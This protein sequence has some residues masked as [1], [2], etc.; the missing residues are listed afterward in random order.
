[1]TDENQAIL[2]A[3]QAFYRAFEKR[4]IA[5]LDGILSKGIGTVCIHPGRPAIRGFDKIRSSWDL[6]FKN[7]DYIEIDL[8]VITTE[9]NGDI[10]YV[11]LVE[12]LMQVTGGRRIKAQSMATNI[13]E[14][15]GGN[16]YLIHHHGSPLIR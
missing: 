6:I 8:D 14:R 3:N 16:W 7:T 9:I 4:D 5:A 2:A 15:M 12:N 10:G 1:M 13:F 11:I